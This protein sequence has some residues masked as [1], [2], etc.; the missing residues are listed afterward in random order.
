MDGKSLKELSST[1]FSY[2]MLNSSEV[3]LNVCSNEDSFSWPS[4]ELMI[5]IRGAICLMELWVPGSSSCEQT[6]S[7][8]TDVF[9]SVVAVMGR[10]LPLRRSVDPV[11]LICFIKLWT[12]M[13]EHS[14]LGCSFQILYAFQSFSLKSF[15]MTAFCLSIKSILMRSSE[16]GN[17]TSQQ[18]LVASTD[19]DLHCNQWLL[20]LPRLLYKAKK[21]ENK[22]IQGSFKCWNQMF[23]Y[24]INFF[25]VNFCGLFILPGK[26]KFQ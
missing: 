20:S 1:F 25:Y 18:G 2:G 19:F 15:L 17:W 7:S 12:A 3:F 11:S 9:S 22:L 13:W 14:K 10:L 5:D 6:S 4:D 24:V 8:K 21:K 26:F 23:L 16:L